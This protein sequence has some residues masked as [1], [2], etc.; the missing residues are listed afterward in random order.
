M[1]R[2]TWVVVCQDCGKRGNTAVSNNT[3][4]PSQNPYL[5]GKCPSHISGNPNMPHRPHWERIG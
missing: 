1:E 5:P 2:T 4:Q 3:C